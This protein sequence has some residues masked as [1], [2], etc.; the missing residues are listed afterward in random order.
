[1]LALL[2]LTAFPFGPESLGRGQERK[3][4]Q[5]RTKEDG[6]LDLPD[7]KH[8]KEGE[9]VK[10]AQTVI[11]G[12]LF[13]TNT[14][15]NPI[16]RI[17]IRML[18][19]DAY[20]EFQPDKAR[21]ILSA[22]FPKIALITA[23]QN[24]SDTYK[25][26]P[27]EQ[28][29]AQLRREM[30]AIISARNSVL[31]RGLV[32]AEKA[33]ETKSDEHPNEVDEVLSTVQ[34]L[35]ETDPEAA[36]RIIKE[37]LKTGVSD[38]LVFL[39]MRLRETSPAEASAIFNQLFSAARASGDLW[40]F[41][42]LLPYILPTELDRLVGGRH[43]LTDPQRMKDANT[44]IEYAADLLYRRILT[45]SPDNMAPELI[46][47]EYYVWRNLLSVFNDLRPE[48][49]WLINTRLR[50][51]TTVLP[52]SV[53]GPPQSPWSEE[54]INELIT[55]AKSSFGE[56]RDEY[57][58]AAASNA[59]RFGQGDLDRAVSI[60]E[61]IENREF[62]DSTTGTFYF[63]AGLKYLRSEGPD[64]ALGLARKINLPVLRARLY[65][66]I[67][68]TLSSVKALER[69]EALR[70]ELLN[71]LRNSEKTSDTAWAI[72]E[73]LDGSKNDKAERNFAAFDILASVLNSPGL[74]PVNKV[75]NRI[76][77]YPEFHD[78]RKSLAPLAKTDFDRGLEATRMV[79]NRE[80]SMQM[81]AALCGDYLRMHSKNRKP[82]PKAT[83][84][85][86][87]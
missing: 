14:I 31:A 23:P 74:D 84:K 38:G 18:A 7:E 87:K 56:K 68:R 35:A 49:V 4:P 77:W 11:E 59:W 73:Y 46:R 79:N 26:R 45:D 6:N 17:R 10:Q 33:K 37:S 29:R 58:S 82:S 65:L 8:N 76:Y 13:S 3:T 71:W 47:R 62:R 52:Q 67:I 83:P 2:L 40:Q 43:Y 32:A 80:V 39:L 20:W 72:L 64:Y 54:K 81:Q 63:Q 12:I 41:Q 48:S 42:Q 36:A 30:L 1:M 70:E 69:T 44:L 34:S 19:A 5:E 86:D 51:L 50:Q 15:L 53:Q 75:K 27:I 25:G 24:E 57:F 9:R 16:V 85:S 60:A 61:N 66:A 28:V 55:K 78:F 22:E 21:E